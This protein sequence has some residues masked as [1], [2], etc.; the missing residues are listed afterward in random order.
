M[1]HGAL[2]IIVQLFQP[3]SLRKT[4]GPTVV[5][6]L[7]VNDDVKMTSSV[8]GRRSV[9]GYVLLPSLEVVANFIDVLSNVN[10][11]GLKLRADIS[12]IVYEQPC[13]WAVVPRRVCHVDEILKVMDDE[14]RARTRDDRPPD[15]S[16]MSL[17]E[18]GLALK[19]H[20]LAPR[21]SQ[22]RRW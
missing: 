14:Q 18:V 16:G 12:E 1:E 10:S 21:T 11:P 3:P 15:L 4:S 19:S 6:V 20:L 17:A 7:A 5:I 8:D 13:G 2:P 9:L 22:Q